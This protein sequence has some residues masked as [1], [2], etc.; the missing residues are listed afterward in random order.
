MRLRDGQRLVGGLDRRRPLV[1]A[2]EGA[3]QLGQQVCPHLHIAIQRELTKRGLQL[4]DGRL[5]FAAHDQDKSEEGPA[6][7]Y[8]RCVAEVAIEAYRRANARFG[9]LVVAGGIDL[10]GVPVQQCRAIGRRG[11]DRQRL[12]NEV[13]RLTMAAQSC[14][15]L[16]R[17]TQGQACLGCDRLCFG[18]GH[19]RLVGCDVVAGQ[20]AG[21]LIATTSLEVSRRRQVSFASLRF[22]QCRVG[23]FAHQRLRETELAAL[24]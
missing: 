8:V 7:S 18:A 6:A 15:P 16:R 13:G 1:V 4:V 23:D 9:G 2:V 24:R 21:Q 5:H 10:L 3:R 20:S 14:C 17:P 12:R 22:G 19:R 11:R